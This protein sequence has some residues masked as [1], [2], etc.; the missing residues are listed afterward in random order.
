MQADRLTPKARADVAALVDAQVPLGRRESFA[1]Y[2]ER[3][4]S[5]TLLRSVN[6]PEFVESPDYL[7]K[8]GEIYPKVMDALIE[9]NSGHYQEAVL[10]GAIGT[11]KSTLAV[12]STA[13]SVYQLS[14]LRRPHREFGLDPSSEIVIIFQSINARTARSVDYERFKALIDGSSYFFRQFQYDRRVESELRFPNRIIVRPVTGDVAGA[15]GQNVIGGVIDEINHMERV[16]RSRRSIDGGIYDQAVT[17]YNSIVRRRKSRF[18]RRGRLPGLLCLVGSKRYPGQFTDQRMAAAASDPTIFVYDRRTWDVLPED[19][20]SGKWFSVFIGDTQRQPRILG[21]GE[22]LDD[23]DRA[24]ELRV[25]LEYREDFSR[26]IHEALREIGGVST[27][28]VHPYFVNREAVASSFGSRKSILNRTEVDFA[29]N[30]VSAFP[31]LIENPDQPRWVHVDLALTGDAAGI[32]CGYVPGFARISRGSVFEALPRIAIDFTLR[33]V[34]PRQGEISFERI[35]QLIYHLTE[36]GLGIRW[37]S[38]DGFQSADSIQQLRLKGYQSGVRSID[39]TTD[40]YDTLKSAIYDRRVSAPADD[41][42]LGELLSL[43]L[44]REWGKVD[45]PS[46]QGASK[47]VADA[48]AGVVHGLTMRR[49]VWVQ[50]GIS[51]REVPAAIHVGLRESLANK[52]CP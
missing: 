7:G 46:V 25:P 36:L 50:H 16:E 30:Q 5:R 41:H 19:R 11:A 22:S 37:V 29:A 17:L 44:D 6:V 21:D 28:S 35:R 24:L 43:E 13:W 39:R 20:F 33:V 51:L 2:L 52:S 10:T 31:G 8:A 48:L 12:Y 38:F 49:A 27:L 3:K 42:L 4:T 40:A 14:L 18:M 9:M 23:V 47:D 32:A 1:Q 34:P 45:H 26:D 15:I